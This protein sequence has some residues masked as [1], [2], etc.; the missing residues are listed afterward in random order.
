MAA[1]APTPPSGQGR[2]LIELFADLWRETSTLVHEEAQLARAEIAE[3]VDEISTGVMAMAAGALVLFAGFL[4]LLLA[5][6]GALELML[7]TEHAVWLAPLIVGAVVML[8]GWIAF[9]AG[10]KELRARSL[11]PERTMESL[12]RDAQLAREHLP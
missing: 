11:R 1:T 4:V 3:K 5:A 10:R 6:V 7:D 9:A 12:R 8:A 2:S